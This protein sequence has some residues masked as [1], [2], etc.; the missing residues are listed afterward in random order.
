[1]HICI[2]Y[3]AHTYTNT[4]MQNTNTH[5]HTHTHTNSHTFTYTHPNSHVHTTHAYTRKHTNIHDMHVHMCVSL[6]V[7]PFQVVCMEKKAD[8]AFTP[9]G[10]VCVC[11]ACSLIGKCTQMCP[12]CRDQHDGT[13]KVFFC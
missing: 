3:V 12:M 1:M 13:L 2:A 4:R 8:T 10:H 7:H 11:Q 5:T 6:C 9:C